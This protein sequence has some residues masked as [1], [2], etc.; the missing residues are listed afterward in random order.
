[1]CRALSGSVRKSP[2]RWVQNA[3]R[4]VHVFWPSSTQPP[5][6]RRALLVTLARSLPAFGSDQPWHQRSSPAAMRRRMPVLLGGRAELEQA[7]REQEDPVLRD[8]G[9]APAR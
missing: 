8:P 9:G 6:T 5:S 7:R 4:V 1:M 2:N 3:P